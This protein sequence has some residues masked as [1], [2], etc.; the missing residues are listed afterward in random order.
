MIEAPVELPVKLVGLVRRGGAVK[1]VLKVH[2]RTVEVAAG[3]S[4][5]DYRVLAVDDDGVRLRGAD[6]TVV[7]LS[8]GGS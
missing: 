5:G 4:A 3:E 2:G 1:A 6:G 8:A 7:T